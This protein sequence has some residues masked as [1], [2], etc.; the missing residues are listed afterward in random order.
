MRRDRTTGAGRQGTSRLLSD[1]V[2]GSAVRHVGA[3]SDME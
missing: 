2:G 3:W 1:G